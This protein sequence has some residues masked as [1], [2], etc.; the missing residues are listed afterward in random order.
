[1]DN[2]DW[3]KQVVETVKTKLDLQHYSHQHDEKRL[4]E[5]KIPSIEAWIKG[6]A[7]ADFVITDSFH[8]TLFSIIFN[9]PFISLVNIERGASRFCSILSEF[10]LKDRLI[11]DYDEENIINLLNQQI[12]CLLVNKK[13]IQFKQIAKD[14]LIKKLS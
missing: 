7:D 5:E 11:I 12:D 14:S 2:S 13:I 3:K 10:D 9:K 4:Y 6:F 1:M 8:G